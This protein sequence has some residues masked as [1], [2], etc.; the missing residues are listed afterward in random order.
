MVW[1]SFTHSYTWPW[2][3]FHWLQGWVRVPALGVIPRYYAMQYGSTIVGLLVLVVGD[4]CGF[5]RVLSARQRWSPDPSP[6]LRWLLLMFGLA[7]VAGFLRAR[8]TVGTAITPIT[9]DH[10]MLIFGLTALD[11]A[12]WQVL[13]YCVLV[14][15]Y[16]VWII[17]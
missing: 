9:F 15:S 13:L 11:L 8:A 12:F 17:T 16:Q 6:V 5:G 10:F 4:C 1:D 3:H 7:G 14:S 2:Y